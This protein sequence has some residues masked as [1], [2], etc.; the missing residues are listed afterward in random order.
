MNIENLLD[1]WQ[2]AEVLG[3][4]PE[5]VRK[6]A[7]NHEIPAMIIRNKWYFNLEQIENWMKEKMME[8]L[9]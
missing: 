6:M 4:H 3:T 7:K 2:V 1:R 9:K 5:T 8:N